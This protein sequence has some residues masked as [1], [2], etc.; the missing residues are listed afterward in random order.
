MLQESFMDGAEVVEAESFTGGA[1]FFGGAVVDGAGSFSGGGGSF[2]A[3]AVFG[4]FDVVVM[5]SGA[6]VGF[7]GVATGA[8]TVDTL[9]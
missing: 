5:A 8:V 7:F 1:G 3:G 2:G 4:P 6:F 9:G